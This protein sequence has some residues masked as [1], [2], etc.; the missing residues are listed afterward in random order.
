MYVMMCVLYKKLI[1][2]KLSFIDVSCVVYTPDG[3]CKDFQ[4]LFDH[5]VKFAVDSSDPDVNI[6]KSQYTVNL[7]YHI[8]TSF[9]NPNKKCLDVALPFLCRGLF[10]TCDPAFNVSV[11]QRVCAR[12]CEILTVFVCNELWN[13]LSKQ[14]ANLN[15][16]TVSISTCNA[17]IRANGGEAPDCMDTLDGGE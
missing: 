13:S 8:L 2:F 5:P 11:R 16:I 7:F 3:V 12:T 14:L 4:S 6:S 10:P 9:L 1:L 15:L 17:N